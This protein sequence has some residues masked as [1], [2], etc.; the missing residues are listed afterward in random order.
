M[1][2]LLLL[3]VVLVEFGGEE[4]RSKEHLR[5]LAVCKPREV[6]NKAIGFSI[7]AAEPDFDF[8]PV[9]FM[10][11]VELNACDNEFCGVLLL[12]VCNQRGVVG[13]NLHHWDSHLGSVSIDLRFIVFR[14]QG[15]ITTHTVDVV[16]L[17]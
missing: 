16:C 2:Q 6:V 4:P 1:S 3:P 12:V 9:E 11:S 17:C 15:C 10:D 14:Y 8:G 13:S 7:A 5:I